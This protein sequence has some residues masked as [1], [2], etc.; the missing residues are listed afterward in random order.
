MPRLGRGCLP[1]PGGHHEEGQASAVF[2][3]AEKGRFLPESPVCLDGN[4]FPVLAPERPVASVARRNK[5]R[6]QAAIRMGC[7]SKIV[8]ASFYAGG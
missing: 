6:L 1:R 7:A 8:C 3:P 2:V 4:E 5:E